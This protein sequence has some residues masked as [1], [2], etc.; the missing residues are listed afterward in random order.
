[1]K[2]EK[3]TTRT[4]FLTKSYALKIP[5]FWHEYG[6][7]KWKMFLRGILA[8]LDE[9]Y[10]WSYSYRRNQLCPVIFTFP[11]GLMIVMKRAETLSI[12]EYDKA[13]LE[14]DFNGLPLDNK[15]SNFGKFENRIVLVDYADSR[16]MCSDC[17]LKFKKI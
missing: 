13:K 2:I 16:Y 5:R 14:K 15:I 17:S 11:L 8:N 7:H 9:K 4:V 1:M 12:S 10:W 3:G 6:G